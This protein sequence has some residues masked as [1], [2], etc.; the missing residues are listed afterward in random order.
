M[1]RGRFLNRSA[2]H[3]LTLGVSVIKFAGFLLAGILVPKIVEKLGK[4][5]DSRRFFQICCVSA[6]VLHLLFALTTYGGLVNK[7]AGQSASIFTAILVILFTGLTTIPLE[8]KNL[9]QKEME[10]ESVVYIEWK[11][12]LFYVVGFSAVKEISV[13]EILPAASGDTP[14][15][16]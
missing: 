14:A 4:R 2:K 1:S 13:N 11:M 16:K 10:A 5:A 15:S 6:I 12:R 3:S 9:M 7:P 8:F